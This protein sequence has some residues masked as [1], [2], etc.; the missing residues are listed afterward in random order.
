[1]GARHF[2]SLLNVLYLAVLV[3]SAAVFYLVTLGV[4]LGL[5]GAAYFLAAGFTLRGKSI[6]ILV[7]AG[8][9][10]YL[11][12]RGFYRKPHYMPLGIRA[13]REDHPRLF[14]VLDEVAGNVGTRQVDEVFLTPAVG[15]GVFE[16]AGLLGLFGRYHRVLELGIAALHDLTLV[17]LKA[18][19]A[20]EYAH[21]TS[22]ETLFRRF[23]A[24]VLTGLQSALKHLRTGRWWRFSP[25]YNG[26]SAYEFFFRYFAS[27]FSR[28]REYSAD[29]LA[30]ECYGGNV[31]LFEGPAY[32]G[33]FRLLLEGRMMRN[34][35]SAFRAYSRTISPDDIDRIRREILKIRSGLL[36][37]HP[38]PARR[39]A[40]IR[41]VHRVV[42]AP[43]ENARHIFENPEAVEEK[44]TTLLTGKLM[45]GLGLLDA[46]Q[47]GPRTPAESRT[48]SEEMEE[49]ENV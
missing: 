6:E 29:R 2:N 45:G 23:V 30:S 11:V 49:E 46:L 14:A 42:Q 36:D 21:F 9:I 10:A 17:E 24:R 15:I 13:D 37:S 18:I 32:G 44:L 39:I 28:Q 35:F 48:P 33:L 16:R 26:L 38:C 5:L 3:F 43:G 1:M 7:I 19:L 40:R 34:L 12:F 8:F 22:R 20:H 47:P 27:T 4:F 41:S 31:L 25:L